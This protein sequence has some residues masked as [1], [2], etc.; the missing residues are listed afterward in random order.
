MHAIR[1][2]LIDEK[3]VDD[4]IAVSL[5]DGTVLFYTVH[6]HNVG[7]RTTFRTEQRKQIHDTRGQNVL[8]VGITNQEEYVSFFS[9]SK[10]SFSCLILQFPSSTR[11][12]LITDEQVRLYKLC[13]LEKKE[14]LKLTELEGLRIMNGTIARIESP[15]SKTAHC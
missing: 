8:S 10:F 7:I 3:Q 2:P 13:P 9:E 4:V 1:F 6:E 5:K 12:L 11:F 15:K 14:S